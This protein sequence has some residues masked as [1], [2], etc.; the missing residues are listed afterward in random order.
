MLRRGGR[1]SAAP[2]CP[3]AAGSVS[4]VTTL[5]LSSWSPTNLLSQ[6]T[7]ICA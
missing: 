7:T 2:T 1:R 6:L 3:T 4:G 5:M